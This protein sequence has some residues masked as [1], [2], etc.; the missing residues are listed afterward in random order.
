M[1]MIPAT[2]NYYA[3]MYNVWVSILGNTVFREAP[4]S[5]IILLHPIIKHLVFLLMSLHWTQLFICDEETSSVQMTCY[6]KIQCGVSGYIAVLPSSTAV[7][8]IGSVY[9][10]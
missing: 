10:S 5:A 9:L 1:S 8:E 6:V 7:G 2:K 3:Y 4:T